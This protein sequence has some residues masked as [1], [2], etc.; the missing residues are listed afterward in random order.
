[1]ATG[2]LLKLSFERGWISPVMRCTGGAVLGAVVGAIGWRLHQRYRTYGAALIGCGCGIIYLSVWAACRL[3]EVIPPTTGIVGLALVSVA[4]AMVAFAINVEALGTTAALGAF[5]APVL[6]G[7]DDANANLL[8]LY[9][10][11]MAAGLGLVAARQ[12]WRLTM[13]VVAASYFGV[14]IAGAGDRAVPWALLLYG[15]IGGTAGLYLG[16]REQWWETRLLTFSGGW[17]LLAAASERM[18]PHW[19]VFIAGLIL[20][21]PV[22]WHALRNPKALP[23]RLGAGRPSQPDARSRAEGWSAGEA[24]YFFTTPLLLGWAA[25]G[26]APDRFET[27]PGL[28]P[29]ARGGSLSARRLPASPSA[30]RAGRRGGHGGRRPGAVGRHQSGLG[31][32][33]H[34]PVVACAGPQARPIGW[35]LVRRAHVGRRG[36]ASVR[37]G[38]RAAHRGGRR[39][40]RPLGSRP[41]GHDRR[42]ARPR[43]RPLQGEIEEE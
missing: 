36:P 1:M 42:G 25:Y 7:S 6:L 3:Y 39:L 41:L 17:T 14:G 8:L 33:C 37:G 19:P 9:L 30:V 5:M 10:A 22:W 16:L 38:P 31:A 34:G 15:V 24:L 43:G 40:R 26:L 21:A 11:S 20:S 13:F 4:L 27:T 23:L 2:Y 28:L 18:A 32:P 35:P 29:A 12:R